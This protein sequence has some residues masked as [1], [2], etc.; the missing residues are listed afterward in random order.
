MR[1][2][3]IQAKGPGAFISDVVDES[4]LHKFMAEQSA[5]VIPPHPAQNDS[6]LLPYL[7]N[8]PSFVGFVG[9]MGHRDVHGENLLRYEDAKSNALLSD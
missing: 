1:C 5:R 3:I 7:R 8:R 2:L 9:P 6:H 4:E